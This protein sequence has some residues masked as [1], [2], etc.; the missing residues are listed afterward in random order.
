MD[1]QEECPDFFGLLALNNTIFNDQ[2]EKISL[3]IPIEKNLPDSS[4]QADYARAN[5]V[6]PER[7]V[8]NPNISPEE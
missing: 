1:F 2:K 4:Y 5:S 6:R 3:I 8:H 7:L